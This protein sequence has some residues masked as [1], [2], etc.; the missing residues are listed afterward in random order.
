MCIRGYLLNGL[1]TSISPERNGRTTRK[2]RKC[3]AARA[4]A[5]YKPR[6][7]QQLQGR[8]EYRAVTDTDIRVIRA[9]A[10]GPRELAAIYGCHRNTIM[11]I[12]NG[13]YHKHVQ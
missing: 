10:L 6:I 7:G 11:R 1:N 9:S 3:D 12:R 5:R 13:R 4:R 2:C 8:R